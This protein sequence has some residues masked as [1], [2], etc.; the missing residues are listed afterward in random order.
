MSYIAYESGS[1]RHRHIGRKKFCAV[2]IYVTGIVALMNT[3]CR[4]AQP[5]IYAVVNCTYLYVKP[6][7]L[8]CYVYPRISCPKY[9]GDGVGGV[10]IRDI[11]YLRMFSGWWYPVDYVCAVDVIIQ[12]F[13]SNQMKE[14]RIL[15]VVFWHRS[16]SK[17][18]QGYS[19]SI[20]S[21]MI[22]TLPLPT[23]HL[24]SALQLRW[25]SLSTI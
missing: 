18:N 22:H 25:P 6:G 14:C 15:K 5:L 11:K 4:A 12:S 3:S 20:I 24:R 1:S 19:I 8:R 23:T 17:A 16:A 7:I 2:V 10:T 9:A 21:L 13:T